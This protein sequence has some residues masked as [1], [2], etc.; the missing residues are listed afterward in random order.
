M[1]DPIPVDTDLLVGIAVCG[2][3]SETMRSQIRQ[4]GFRYLAPLSH[5][6]RSAATP[7]PLR[8]LRGA[9]STRAGS[10]PRRLRGELARRMEAASRSVAGYFPGWVLPV[11]REIARKLAR[12]IAIKI[13]AETVGEKALKLR[14]RVLRST[15]NAAHSG[16]ER[17]SLGVVL[18]DITPATRKD[19]VALCEKW[20]ES[21]PMLSR[22]ERPRT[23]AAA[24]EA[25][26]EGVRASKP[27]TEGS[28]INTEEPSE[29]MAEVST[30]TELQDSSSAASQRSAHRGVFEREILQVDEEARV[31]QALLGR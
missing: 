13:P 20:N 29:T 5:T 9:Q 19:L 23:A 15:P 22:S 31:V 12:S 6:P 25:R 1:S 28:R 21:P 7:A 26:D 8:D 3:I 4:Q 30:T 27:Q 10:S 2:D 14:G 11:G 18:S 24:A 16:S 17:T